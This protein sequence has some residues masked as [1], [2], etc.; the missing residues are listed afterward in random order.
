MG[1]YWQIAMIVLAPLA[2]ALLLT[3]KSFKKSRRFGTCPK[4]GYDLTGV[5]NSNPH[6]AECG[7]FVPPDYLAAIHRSRK[8]KR[9]LRSAQTKREGSCRNCGHSSAGNTSGVCPECGTAVASVP[10]VP[11]R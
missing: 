3:G 11:A 9:R 8:S 6:C 2:I 5:I 7:S 10:D 1:W 4:C